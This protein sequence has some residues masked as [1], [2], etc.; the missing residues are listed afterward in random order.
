MVFTK[1]MYSEAAKT[2]PYI[3]SVKKQLIFKIVS[4]MFRLPVMSEMGMGEGKSMPLS[5]WMEWLAGSSQ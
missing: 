1:Q 5:A 3:P 2:E 4:E